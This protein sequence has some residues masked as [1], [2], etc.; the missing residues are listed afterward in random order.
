MK[1]HNIS[2]SA[3][4]SG[5]K[6]EVN[7]SNEVKKSK[8]RATKKRKLE[9]VNEDEGDIDEPVK[10]EAKVKGEIKHEDA[11]VK[12]EYRNDDLPS[13]AP[14]H[15]TST[16]SQPTSSST[17]Q[18][19]DDDEVLFISA[20]ERRSTLDTRAFGDNPQPELHAHMPVAPGVQ[21]IDY[22]A[23]M[24]FPQQ[25]AVAAQH[26]FPP[27]RA[28]TP[29]MSSSYAVTPTTWVYPHDSHGYF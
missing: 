4:V 8:A 1:A 9:E 10:Q 2:P 5:V 18:S 16:Q 28:M 23:N 3:G 20:I 14:L 19:D 7:D 12:R 6:K 27:T 15:Y 24:N 13:A 21:S 29:S 11:I 26:T 17:T 22:A 25:L